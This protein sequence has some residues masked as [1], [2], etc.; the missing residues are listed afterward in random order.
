MDTYQIIVIVI[1]ITNVISVLVI[2]PMKETLKS[3]QKKNDN[4]AHDIN[5]TEKE[6]LRLRTYTIENFVTKSEL[7]ESVAEIKQSIDEIARDNKHVRQSMHTTNELLNQLL[8]REFIN[9]S[10]EHEKT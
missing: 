10:V 9:M 4:Q 5:E 3:I 1:G 6:L 8:N 7:K 2:F